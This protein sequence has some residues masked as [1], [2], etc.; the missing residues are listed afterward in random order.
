[1]AKE[2]AKLRAT[3]PSLQAATEAA[4]L[5]FAQPK[6]Q[7]ILAKN[8]SQAVENAISNLS[9]GGLI[10]V[11]I[12]AACVMGVNRTPKCRFVGGGEWWTLLEKRLSEIVPRGWLVLC[13]SDKFGLA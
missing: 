13:Q 10:E 4:V 9:A 6:W 2:S 8:A 3:P 7:R 1:M 11:R 5:S 12:L